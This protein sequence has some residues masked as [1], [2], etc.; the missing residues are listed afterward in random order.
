VVKRA[1]YIAREVRRQPEAAARSLPAPHYRCACRVASHVH[2]KPLSTTWVGFASFRAEY[3]LCHTLLLTAGDLQV[4]RFWD[5]SGALVS[6][7]VREE[8]DARK[9]A[10]SALCCHCDSCCGWPASHAGSKRCVHAKVCNAAMS[11]RRWTCTRAPTASRL[12]SLWECD[13]CVLCH[14]RS[15]A[16]MCMP[17]H[18]LLCYFACTW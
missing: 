17:R 5:K 7:I 14:A 8:V 3:L 2:A 15:A 18:G 9:C 10:G 4:R 16:I 12:W 1:A 6:Y 13:T 11:T